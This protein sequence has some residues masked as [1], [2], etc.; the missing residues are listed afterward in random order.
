MR[1][2]VTSDFSSESE[3]AIKY[4]SELSSQ[5]KVQPSISILHCVEHISSSRLYYGL[6]IDVENI[7]LNCE[8]EASNELSRL[9]EKYFSDYTQVETVIRRSEKSVS[10]EI[11]KYAEESPYDL[12]VISRKGQTA[13]SHVFF[14]SVSEYVLRHAKGPVILV[15]EAE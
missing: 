2:I 3:K 11:I 1:I 5:F 8:E 9:S 7:I 6:G 10:S 15:P 13:L 14:G 12:I 4:L